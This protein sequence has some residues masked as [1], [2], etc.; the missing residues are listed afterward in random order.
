MNAILGFSELVQDP[1]MEMDE[2]SSF[3]KIINRSSYHLLN[4]INDLVD[5]SKINAN[6][7]KI[8]SN[9]F[10]LNSIM[11]ELIQYFNGE[12]LNMQK[13]DK[14]ELLYH[15]GLPTGNDL[16]ITDETRLRQILN[17]IIGNAIKFTREGKVK[18]IYELID[19]QLF[20]TISDTGIG[21]NEQQKQ[22]VFER[23][24]Q[25][26][27]NIS[28]EFGGTGLGLAIAKSCVELLGGEIWVESEF[29]VGTK[30]HFLIPYQSP[31]SN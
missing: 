29:G 10:S 16:I 20:F 7:M 6:Q 17:N 5:I 4:L 11:M 9:I 24:A 25:A 8:S 1:T 13:Q 30:M 18:I 12:L 26:D 3:L 27:T 21:M 14:V 19:N 15:Y 28:Q 31:L 23:F 22:I 2:K